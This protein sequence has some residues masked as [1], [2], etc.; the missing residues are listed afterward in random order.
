MHVDIAVINH[1]SGLEM[2]SVHITA[3]K[4]INANPM[5]SIHRRPYPAEKRTMARTAMTAI[6]NGE[7]AN[8]ESAIT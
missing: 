8:T 2:V 7:T 4:T 3:A 5:R 6:L 1:C